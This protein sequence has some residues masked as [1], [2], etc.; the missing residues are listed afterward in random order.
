MCPDIE[1]V[2]A[3]G[4]S[5]NVLVPENSKLT[6]YELG[7]PTSISL[8][9]P[10][11]LTIAGTIV[12]S[13]HNVDS[14]DLINIPNCNSFGMFDKITSV[15]FSNN[16]YTR[17]EG[18]NTIIRVYIPDNISS[19]AVHVNNTDA[20]RIFYLFDAQGNGITYYNLTFNDSYRIGYKVR[21]FN[22]TFNN[23][24]V[25]YIEYTI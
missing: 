20:G 24:K 11:V 14:L 12:D 5:I 21:D 3:S 13:Y 2:D 25:V 23:T 16:G 10:T 4:T 7:T 15:N 9:N 8:I 18:N 6:K 17:E 1:E 22:T 19:A